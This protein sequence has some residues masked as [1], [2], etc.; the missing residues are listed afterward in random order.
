LLL[1]RRRFLKFQPIRNRN[2]PW[3]PCFSWIITKL[4]M[5]V[6]DLTN[7]TF[8]IKIGVIRSFAL[9][10]L[11]SKFIHFL[12]M[13]TK[14]YLLNA[15]AMERTKNLNITFSSFITSLFYI[16]NFFSDTVRTSHHL[17]ITYFD[18]KIINFLS[19]FPLMHAKGSIFVLSAMEINTGIDVRLIDRRQMQNVDI[20]S[21][22]LTSDVM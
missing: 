13:W 15:T 19:Y 11:D 18:S 10:W 6:E 7:I 5:F 4:P 16:S 21:H 22:D 14:W 9:S 8:K 12:L 3:Q 20:N 17:S 1:L 2:F